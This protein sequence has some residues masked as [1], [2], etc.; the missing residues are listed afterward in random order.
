[1]NQENQN[2]EYKRIWQDENL[3][4]ICAFANTSGG[5]I[6]VGIDDEGNA[7]GNLIYDADRDIS[8]IRYNILNLPDTIQFVNG[9]QIVNLY[10]ASGKKYKSIYYTNLSTSATSYY[11]IAHY[12]LEADTIWYNITKYDGNIETRYSRIDTTRRIFNS[13]GYFA[14]STYYHYIQDHLGNNCAVVHSVADTLV[15]S[16]IY[17][18]SGVPM[19]QSLGPNVPL[20]NYTALGVQYTEN[21]GW[22]VQPYLYNGKEFIEAYGLNEYDSQARMYYAP[23]MRTTTMDPMA[24]SYYHISPYAWCGNNPITNVDEDGQY[25]WDWDDWCYRSSY[26]NHDEVPWSEILWNEFIEPSPINQ[27]GP[28]RLVGEF[29]LGNGAQE[30]NFGPDD[31][32][33]QQFT[34]D[35]DR[36]EPIYEE[37]GKQIFGANGKNGEVGMEGNSGYSLGSK[38]KLEKLGIMAHDAANAAGRVF[39][40]V[41]PFGLKVPTGNLAASV[42]GTFKVH[43]K[44]ESYDKDGNAVVSF[45]LN[46]DMSAGSATRPP[47]V[48]YSNMWRK[49]VIPVVNGVAN[50]SLNIPGYM[51]TVGINMTWKKTINNPNL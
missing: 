42:M 30:R 22:D 36:L 19:A 37:V 41:S 4:S 2:T 12:P 39:N 35:N 29:C 11:E 47:L 10:D 9:N 33:T 26:G 44:L 50:S 40:K 16:T 48:G 25:Y 21:F 34:T 31:N 27:I 15:Q 23:I 14:D 7:N 28:L 46:N 13:I 32:F 20:L 49:I 3:K 1:M 24:E 8:V 51:R 45:R 43:W 6:Y 17:Y 38:G 5:T 18:A